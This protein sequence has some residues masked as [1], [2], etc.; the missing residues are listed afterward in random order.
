M[1]ESVRLLTLGVLACFAPLL[2]LFSRSRRFLYD[3]MIVISRYFLV[4][5][6]SSAN[7][8]ASEKRRPNGNIV[9]VQLS[10]DSQPQEERNTRGKTTGEKEE[11]IKG[12]NCSIIVEHSSKHF[13]RNFD[14]FK[15]NLHACWASR[16]T[17]EE[18][19]VTEREV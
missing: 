9:R 15:L 5:F 14:H 7:F 11:E 19:S 6:R 13:G 4:V 3:R 8:N 17:R 10:I 2:F 12:G 18:E 16:R 1:I